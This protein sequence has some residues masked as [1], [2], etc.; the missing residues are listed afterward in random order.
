MRNAIALAVVLTATAAFAEIRLPEASPGQVLTQEIG[1]SKVTITY[2]RPGMKGRKIWGELVP[3]GKVW[4]LG[5]NEAT[6]IELSH[7]AKVNGFDVPAG[8]YA[9]FAIPEAAQWTLIL[10]RK[11]DQWGAYFYKAQDDLI[12]FSAKPEA[13]DPVEWFDIDTVPLSDRAMRVEIAWEKV[14]VPFTIEFETEALVWKQIDDAVANPA[15]TWE[16]YITAARYT[17]QQNKRMDDGM[18]W[19]DEAMRRKESFWNYELKGLMLHKQGN[20]AEAAPLMYKAAE[21]AKG[22]APQEYVDNVLKEVASW[23]K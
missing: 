13:I 1:V 3:A 23:K 4:R 22:K 5:A 15:A 21:L 16:D 19:V 9:L 8:K 17:M 18:K 7:N 14:R 12:R 2:H 6:T 20:D 11:T 10:S